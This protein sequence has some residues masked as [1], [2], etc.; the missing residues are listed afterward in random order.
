MASKSY[1]HDGAKKCKL[2]KR[3][4]SSSK[5]NSPSPHLKKKI[6]YASAV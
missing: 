5:F 6:F 1:V 2:F 3:L 4:W